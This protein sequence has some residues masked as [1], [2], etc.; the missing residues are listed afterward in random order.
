[1]STSSLGEDKVLIVLLFWGV[2]QQVKHPCRV[3]SPVTLPH[4]SVPYVG[5]FHVCD[6]T[7]TFEP[8]TVLGHFTIVT[9][10]VWVQHAWGSL[11]HFR[12]LG[13]ITVQM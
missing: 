1:M 10:L 4:K 3:L 7:P 8:L 12:L 5:Y 13:A 9:S 2:R 6:I 11:C